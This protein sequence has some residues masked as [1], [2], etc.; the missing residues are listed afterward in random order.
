[1][2]GP[3]RPEGL[4]CQIAVASPPAQGTKKTLKNLRALGP[5]HGPT[6]HPRREPDA[7]RQSLHQLIATCVT[8]HPRREPG[9][10]PTAVLSAHIPGANRDQSELLYHQRIETCLTAY[11]TGEPG[12]IPIAVPSDHVKCRTTITRLEPG[13]LPQET[14]RPPAAARPKPCRHCR[15]TVTP[16]PACWGLF[17]LETVPGLSFPLWVPAST[18]AR[19]KTATAGRPRGECPGI[20]T[21]STR[22]WGSGFRV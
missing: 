22:F 16:T 15:P 20:E 21:P 3:P 13:T 12:S 11:S 6:A 14:H 5:A 1:M 7:S 19:G 4:A 17:G 9:S 18:P 8:T 2:E 10:I